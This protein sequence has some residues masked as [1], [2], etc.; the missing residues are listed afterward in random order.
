MCCGSMC[1]GTA[2]IPGRGA[3]EWTG[4]GPALGW[5][6]NVPVRHGTSRHDF[7]AVFLNSLEKAAD[8]IR[9]ELVLLSAGFDAHRRDPIGSLGLEPE[10]FADLTRLVLQAA[11]P[12]C[13]GRLV[14]L[15]AGGR[16]RE[17]LGHAAPL[18]PEQLPLYHR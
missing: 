15:L 7:R 13:Q 1:C 4:T 18:P 11:A 10:D 9:P 16:D 2:F 8:R 17:A 6:L 14:S 12:H 5:T 3:R